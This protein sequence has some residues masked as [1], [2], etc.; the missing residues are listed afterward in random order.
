MDYLSPE[1]WTGKLII[2]PFMYT[3]SFNFTM[4]NM[5]AYFIH[6]ETSDGK[7]TENFKDMNSRAYP[8][9]KAGHIQYVFYKQFDCKILMKCTCI[10]EMKKGLMYNIRV[11]FN[12]S[13]DIVFAVCGC[14]A[15]RG[16]TCTCKHLGAFCYFLE[17]FCR[18]QQTSYSSST[19][20]LQQWNQQR[21]R[22]SGPRPLDGIKFVKSEYRKE[23]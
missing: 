4:A 16:P 9:F 22:S 12:T 20:S 15:G 23:K 6:R 3:P 2:E 13:S 19:S 7:A 17:E 18:N 1:V 10:P 14:P 5:V 21:K 8:L 11:S